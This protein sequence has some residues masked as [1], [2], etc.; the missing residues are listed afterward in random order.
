MD[1]P[2][3]V[4]LSDNGSPEQNQAAQRAANVERAIRTQDDDIRMFFNNNVDV[5][6][7]AGA[8]A[9]MG[10][11]LHHFI[12]DMVINWNTRVF[13]PHDQETPV[14][15][16]AAHDIEPADPNVVPEEVD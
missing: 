4:D 6:L 13:L 2:D 15:D 16:D 5:P 11:N 3:L 9:E 8:I 1:M 10:A 14:V 7:G 12:D